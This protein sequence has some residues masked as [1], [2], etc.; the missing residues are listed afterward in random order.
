[1]VPHHFL[2]FRLY[3]RP[4]KGSRGTSGRKSTIRINWITNVMNIP[5]LQQH[6]RMLYIYILLWEIG[7]PMSVVEHE[8]FGD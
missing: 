5:I 7:W 2:S 3:F 6:N 4:P 8:I 1:M